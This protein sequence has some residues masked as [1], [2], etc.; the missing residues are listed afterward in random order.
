MNTTFH[1]I[2]FNNWDRKQYFYYFTKMLPMRYSLS[3]EVD[4]T[5]T[6]NMIKKDNRKFFP[7]YLY[8]VSRVIG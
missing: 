4:I 1:P 8:L 5:N 2:D 6:Y 3:V 7:A